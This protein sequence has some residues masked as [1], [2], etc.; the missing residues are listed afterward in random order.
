MKKIYLIILLAFISATA[1]AQLI[2]NNFFIGG[3][4]GFNS[5]TT[6]NKNGSSSLESYKRTEVNFTPRIGYFIANKTAL[7][8]GLG[9]TSTKTVTT[10]PNKSSTT[11]T[12]T[13]L[14]AM[15]FLRRYKMVSESFGFLGEINATGYFG[16]GKVETYD[17]PNNTTTTQETGINGFGAMLNGGIFWFASSHVGIEATAGVLGFKSLTTKYENTNPERSDTESD[18]FFGLNSLQLNLGFHY[19]FF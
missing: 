5:S 13:P 2:R 6:T 11:N 10:S 4:M 18:I 19:Y 12:Q 14:S 17:G 15:I 9:Y 1:S 3:S 16:S 8:L 7:G